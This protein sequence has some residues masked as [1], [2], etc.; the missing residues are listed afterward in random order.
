MDLLFHNR[1]VRCGI[2][3]RILRL[4]A[5]RLN[6]IEPHRTVRKNRAVKSIDF[7]V[8]IR[9]LIETG[10][11]I[12]VRSMVYRWLAEFFTGTRSPLKVAWVDP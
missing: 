6:G 9:P 11:W 2:R 7:L 8:C 4:G 12:E 10:K 5:V 1:T 3:G